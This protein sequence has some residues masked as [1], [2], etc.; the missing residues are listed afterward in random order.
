MRQIQ[1][2]IC[3]DFTQYNWIVLATFFATVI[4]NCVSTLATFSSL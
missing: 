3:S 4:L 1:L 2:T